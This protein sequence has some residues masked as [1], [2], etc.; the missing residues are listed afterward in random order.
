M[1]D[2][3]VDALLAHCPKLKIFSFAMASGPPPPIC[4]RADSH[5]F[6]LGSAGGSPFRFC[7]RSRSLRI[8]VEWICNFDEII[9]EDVPCLERLLFE[10]SYDQRPIKILHVPRLEVLGF[11]DLQVHA[12]EIGGVVIRLV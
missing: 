6:L 9:A 12:L 1:E 10:C 11:L 4:S 2:R 8:V 3:E 7:V 5:C